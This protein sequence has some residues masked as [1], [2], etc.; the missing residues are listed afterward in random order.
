MHTSVQSNAT[1][2]VLIV[3][4]DVDFL[5]LLAGEIGHIRGV[6]IDVARGPKEALGKLEMNSYELIVSDWALA[7]STGPEVLFTA[8]H[9]LDDDMDVVRGKARSRKTPVMFMSGSEKVGQT[10]LL[11]SLHHFEP[12]SF[13]LKSCGPPLIGLMAE[14]LLLRTPPVSGGANTNACGR[15]ERENAPFLP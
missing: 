2:T 11:G 8:D 6:E 5:E 10:R 12:V 1:F 4:D 7:G 13:I 15:S 14:H 3:D 9:I